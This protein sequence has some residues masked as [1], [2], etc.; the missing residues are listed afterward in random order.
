M[1]TVEHSETCGICEQEK[2]KGIHLYTLFV[3]SECEQDMIQT[4]PND[5]KYK[6]YLKKLKDINRPT[7]YS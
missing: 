4:E 6:Y 2:T 5:E 7:L 3:C 1:E